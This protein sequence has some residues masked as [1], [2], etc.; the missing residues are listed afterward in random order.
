MARK[1]Y[2]CTI[3]IETMVIA[4]TEEEAKIL[5]GDVLEFDA[6]SIFQ[7]DSARAARHLAKGWDRSSIPWGSGDSDKTVG[8]WLGLDAMPNLDDD[9]DDEDN[10]SDD[11][12]DFAT[13]DESDDDDV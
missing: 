7:Y 12:L 4:E 13:D 3:E 10:E 1:L 11:D 9:V 2:L 6:A 8:D 5:A